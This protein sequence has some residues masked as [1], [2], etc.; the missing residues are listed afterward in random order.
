MKAM[1]F[2]RYGGPEVL[3]LNDVPDPVPGAGQLLVRMQ[4]SSVNPVDWKL[5]SGALRFLM[6]IKRPATP[7]FDLVGEVLQLGAGVT[8]FK[9]GQQ[10]VARIPNTP[11]GAAAEKALVPAEDCV[12]LPAG[13]ST[14]DAAAVPLA[15]M[16]ALQALHN[17]CGMKL[18]GETKRV[19]IVGG[20]GGVGHYAVQIAHNAGAHVTAVCSG[21]RAEVV[22][23]LGAD[24]V[25]DYREQD[26][27]RTDAP[28]DIILDCAAK[29]P[30]AS[31]EEVLTETGVLSQ[32]TLDPGWI[33]RIA[34]T[35]LSS[36][37]KI[38]PTMLKPNAKDLSILLGWMQQ[39]KLKSLVG[40]S[41]PFTELADA[42][43]LNEKGGTLGKIGITYPES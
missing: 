28:Y 17:D 22:R 30:W 36:K 37:K 13:V 3:T 14:T 33:P 7:G 21:K 2:P 20:S 26:H 4:A 43:R 27:F 8:T 24:V 29:A 42:W 23:G 41:F 40:A 5:A 6:R 18:Q 1:Q 11:G 39:G 10:V 25:I 19:L 32:I 38:K 34:W 12:L 16:T 31:F 35:N 9:V 15:G